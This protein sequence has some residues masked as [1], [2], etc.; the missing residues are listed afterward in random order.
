MGEQAFLAYAEQVLSPEPCPGD[1]LVVDN[2]PTHKIGGVREDKGVERGSCSARQSCCTS[3][4]SRWL[5]RR[6]GA[7]QKGGRQ[8]RRRSLVR[9]RR[10]PSRL[11]PKNAGTIFG[12][13]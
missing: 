7:A 8:N 13:M 3:T 9:H 2:L 1:V 11:D 4:P 12:G 10:M 5:S 6:Q